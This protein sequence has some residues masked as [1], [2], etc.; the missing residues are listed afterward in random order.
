VLDHCH[1]WDKFVNAHFTYPTLDSGSTYILHVDN[2]CSVSWLT[3][4]VKS[5]DYH[6]CSV[7]HRNIVHNDNR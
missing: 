5:E 7:L 3:L 2:I 4:E 1:S 6:N